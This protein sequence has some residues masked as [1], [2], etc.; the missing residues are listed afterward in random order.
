[1]KIW[2]GIVVGFFF[3]FSA[4]V[5]GQNPPRVTYS[6]PEKDDTRRTNFEI[7]GKISANYLI[8]KNN[9]TDNALCIYDENMLLKKRVPM[10]FLPEK[11][12][13]VDYITYPDRV[14]VFYQYQKRRVV[15]C[16]AVA[17]NGDAKVIGGPVTLDTTEI[18]YASTNKMYTVVHSDDKQK[19]ML[20]KVNS[21]NP[22][23]FI[24]STYLLNNQLN[25]LSRSRS[26][27]QME[28]KNE[29]FT[30]FQLSN[31][32]DLVV[33][34]YARTGSNSEYIAK[35]DMMIKYPDSLGFSIRKLQM[36]KQVLDNLLLKVDNTN[37]RVILTSFYA[38]QKRGNIE[39]IYIVDWD[40]QKN[41]KLVDT[42]LVFTDELRILAKGDDGNKK[43]ALN[44]FFMK[45]IY[46]RR[47]GGFVV[48]SEAL[49]TSSRYN[50][51]NR[52]DYW[53]YGSPWMSPMSYSYWSPVYS[54]WMM[55]WNRYGYNNTVSRYFADNVLVLSFDKDAN[56]TWSNVISKS[57]YDDESDNLISY[58]TMNTGGEVHFLFN[59]FERRTFV[60]TDQSMDASGKVTRYPTFK[61]LDKGYEFMPRFGKQVAARQMIVPC[62]YRN[63]LCFA[64]IDF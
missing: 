30:D 35:V 25:L 17:I 46:T 45:G 58:G 50:N 51:F 52:W 19:I 39:G 55:P 62:L 63:F 40:K 27:V 32:G 38:K 33:A 3:L 21:A 34:K 42:A 28:E 4:A 20:F 16:D 1:M 53:N 64:K 37:K 44:D 24:I 15:Y 22:R 49:Y 61:N 10:D 36:G 31:D 43:T 2:Y 12:T 14:L 60:L 26:E 18:N 29:F 41:E 11:V 47:D 56:L 54:P 59:I 5:F 7:V 9:K 6:E 23:L 13:N 48:I 57:Q 8:Y